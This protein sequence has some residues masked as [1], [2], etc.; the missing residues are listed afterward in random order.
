MKLGKSLNELAAEV[1]RQ[2]ESKRDF[3]ADT[4]KVE[5]IAGD[6]TVIMQV[7]QEGFGIRETAHSQLA[8]RLKIPKAYYD[9]MAKE[10]PELL[11]I[12]ANRWLHQDPEVRMVRTLDGKVRAFLSDRYRTLDN[13]DVLAHALP[14]IQKLRV[15]VLSSEV[16]ERRMYLKCIFPDLRM[17]VPGSKRQDDWCYAGFTVSNSEIGFGSMAATRFYYY[18]VCTNGMM[19]ERSLKKYHV[20][21]S[22]H[23]GSDISEVLRD[24]TKQV[25]DKAVWMMLEDTIASFSS[26]DSF[27][28][29]IEAM[30][31]TTQRKI[32]GDVQGAVEIVKKKG[33]LS[34]EQGAGILRHLIEGG[35][36]SQW[37]LV[38]AVTRSA[39]DQSD[40]E[41]ATKLET[42]GGDL[43]VLSDG[44]WKNIAQAKAA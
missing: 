8:E 17:L 16:T 7:G 21:K 34:D 11:A 28:R 10:D 32:E 33:G 30:G 42:L 18:Q 4:R 20:G 35:D 25:A 2:Q 27:V 44:E 39:E 23:D 26:K 38:N 31:E 22:L 9:R 13:F 43:V 5:L 1:T 19:G 40:Y 3:L 24:E 29:E 14:T 36:L 15:Q 12:N 41:M 37:G 6:G